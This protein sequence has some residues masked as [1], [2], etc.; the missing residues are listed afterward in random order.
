[1]GLSV[2]K[3]LAQTLYLGGMS[4]GQQ[5]RCAQLMRFPTSRPVDMQGLIHRHDKKATIP[6]AILQ[7]G[8][9][10][11]RRRCDAVDAVFCWRGE[12]FFRIHEAPPVLFYKRFI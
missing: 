2:A 3:P 7:T 5:I 10:C 4:L 8:L 12:F 9:H 11:C 1:M 6:I